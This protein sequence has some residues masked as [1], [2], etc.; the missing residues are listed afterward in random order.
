M[1]NITFVFSHLADGHGEAPTCAKGLDGSCSARRPQKQLV[2]N[3]RKQTGYHN[4]THINHNTA[5]SQCSRHPTPGS[6]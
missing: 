4:N 1:I 3:S 5:N 6:V 2:Y